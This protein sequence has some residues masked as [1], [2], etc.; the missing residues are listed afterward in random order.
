MKVHLRLAILSVSILFFLSSIFAAD[1]PEFVWP[2]VF[3]DPERD[4]FMYGNF[5]DDFIWS[6]A[7]SAYQIEG[8]W[9]VADKG[10]SIWDKFTHIGGKVANNDTGDVACD[11]YHK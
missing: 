6:S 8:A 1:E 4:A 9:N 3:N 5:P 7:T 2:D 10:E 11:S